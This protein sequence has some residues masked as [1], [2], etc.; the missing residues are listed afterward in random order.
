VI[1]F[2]YRHIRIDKNIPFYIGIGRIND[3]I[4]SH[5]PIYYRAYCK[6]RNNLWKKN[7]SK[8]NYCVEI[9][10]ECNNFNEILNNEIEFI[11]LYGRIDL[12]TG[13]LANLTDG[14]E[15]IVNVSTETKLKISNKLKGIK[16]SDE[17]KKKLSFYFTGRKNGSIHNGLSKK[18]ISIKNSG[19]KNGMYGKFGSNN[20]LSKAI[21][22]FDLNNNFIKEWSCARDIQREINISYKQVS[23]NVRGRQKTCHGFIFKYI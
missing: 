1:Y 5:N 23:D 8:T 14:G 17:T 6:D 20:K 22:Q 4:I 3:C 12:N 15:G 11:K 9:I 2:L 10:F 21:L 18:N 19:N 13:S 16:R 7:T